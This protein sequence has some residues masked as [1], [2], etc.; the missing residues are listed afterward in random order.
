MVELLVT[1]NV[2]RPEVMDWLTGS[3]VV[4]ETVKETLVVWDS[5]PLVPVTVTVYAPADPLQESMEDSAAP[6]LTLVGV[7]LHAR[8]PVETLEVK[9]IVP[10]KPLTAVTLSVEVPV[11]APLKATLFGLA[12]IMKSFIV[13]VTIAVRTMPLPVPVTVTV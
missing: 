13:T 10:V 5:E 8:P 7:T 6:K 2:T 1:L 9:L 4:E 3:V 11:A 12:A